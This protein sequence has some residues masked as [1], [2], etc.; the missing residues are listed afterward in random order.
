VLL[1]AGCLAQLAD[2]FLQEGFETKRGL[3][4]VGSDQGGKFL[5]DRLA[6]RLLKQSQLCI[7]HPS[8]KAVI[9]FL[10]H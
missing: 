4:T 10:A 7:H 2:I 9:L 5:E 6:G 8:R 3:V 1:A